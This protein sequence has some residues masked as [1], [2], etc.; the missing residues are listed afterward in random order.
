M[1]ERFRRGKSVAGVWLTRVEQTILLHLLDGWTLRSRRELDGHKECYLHAPSGETTQTA[2][3]VVVRL[4][5]K[6]L[7]ETNQKFPVATYLL[8]SVGKQIAS[9]LIDAGTHDV[10][11]EKIESN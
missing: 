8:T 6:G 11:S 9:Q 3:K 7:I 1:F 2:N 5:E 10:I 4:R